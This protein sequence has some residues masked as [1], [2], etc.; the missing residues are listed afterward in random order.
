MSN[1]HESISSPGLF[2]SFLDFGKSLTAPPACF[3]VP[4]K[5]VADVIRRSHLAWLKTPGAR[6]QVHSDTNFRRF[7][8]DFERKGLL[9]GCSSGWFEPYREAWETLAART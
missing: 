1:K 4:S 9:I 6:G 5:L 8:P 3:V 7:L 2:Y